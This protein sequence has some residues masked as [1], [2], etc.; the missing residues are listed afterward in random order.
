MN[1]AEE[2]FSKLLVKQMLAR[3][4]DL[5]WK[6]YQERFLEGCPERVRESLR[7][8]FYAGATSTELLLEVLLEKL[9]E[10]KSEQSERQD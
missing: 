5:G 7:H 9:Q 1:I 2:E 8:C 3:A 6:L 10:Y 4:T